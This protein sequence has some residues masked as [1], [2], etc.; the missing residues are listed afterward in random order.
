M[1]AMS[2]FGYLINRV[3]L[4]CLFF[5]WFAI[6]ILNY[7]C[8]VF[9]SSIVLHGMLTK[10]PIAGQDTNAGQPSPPSCSLLSA[11]RVSVFVLL[12]ESLASEQNHCK[13]CGPI[14]CKLL[15]FVTAVV[16]TVIFMSSQK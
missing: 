7:L 16:S 11:G 10:I 6:R 2:P 14:K 12:F 3:E 4:T 1:L 5:F 15:I 13:H 8:D 9:L